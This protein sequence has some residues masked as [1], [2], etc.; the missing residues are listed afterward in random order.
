MAITGAR[1]ASGLDVLRRR[2]RVRTRPAP[3]QRPRPRRLADR[4]D[5][6]TSI[7][8][9]LITIAAAAGIG[10]FYLTQSTHVAAIG[11]QIDDLQAQVAELR[12]EQQQLTFQIGEAR[13]PSTIA[14][15][16]SRELQLVPVDPAAARFAIRSMDLR[17][18]K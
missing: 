2:A 1:P 4:R 15:R 10:L 8:A 12:A 7:S 16:A 13:S 14:E 9:V 11:Y 3:R 18:L 17:L 6:L 5:A